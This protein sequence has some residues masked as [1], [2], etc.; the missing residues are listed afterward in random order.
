[1]DPFWVIVLFGLYVAPSLIA[2][3]RRPV[4]TL[5]VMALNVLLG[6][7]IVGWFASL[8]LAMLLP[9]AAASSAPAAPP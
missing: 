9:P 6:W 8:A 3:A 2:A 4:M 1:M 7:T 5:F